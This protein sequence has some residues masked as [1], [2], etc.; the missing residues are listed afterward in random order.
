MTATA[1]EL[2]QDSFNSGWWYIDQPIQTDD[3]ILEYIKTADIESLTRALYQ[4]SNVLTCEVESFEMIKDHPLLMHQDIQLVLR[5]KCK[6]GGR[7][8]SQRLLRGDNDILFD[9]DPDSLPNYFDDEEP[10]ADK[11]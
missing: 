6:F 7:I 1:M 3:V 11:K 8:L 10:N 9:I 5:L 4:R 2:N